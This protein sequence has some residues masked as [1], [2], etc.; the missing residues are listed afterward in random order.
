MLYLDS[1]IGPIH[2]LMIYKDH[3]DPNTFYYIP[4][5][6]R[7][8]RNE[9][10][11]EFIFLKY[12]R[13]ITDN[14]Q[15]SQQQLGGAFLAFTTD[16][17]IDDD[18][19]QAVK[20]QIG[21]TA[22]GTIN[23]TPA[24]FRKGTVRLSI[25]KDMSTAP[26]APGAPAPPPAGMSFFEQ[27]WGASTPSL[28]GT[29]RATFALALDAE[30]ATLFEAAI[31]SGIC[32]IGV[33]YDCEM[34]GLRPGF[35]VKISADYKRI[36][37][38][39]TLQFGIQ[40]SYASI[41]LKAEI[42]LAWEKL[43]E[44]GAIK[45]E[46]INFTDDE[47]LRKQANAAFEFFKG[48]LLQDFFSPAL[49]PPPFMRSAT[50]L[51]T[52]AASATGA[53]QMN[54]MMPGLAASQ[55]AAAR[56]VAQN[57][58]TLAPTVASPPQSQASNVVATALA[59]AAVTGASALARPPAPPPAAPAPAPANLPVAAR[60]PAAS[61][62]ARPNPAAPAPPR[63]AVAAPP[64]PPAAATGTR[65]PI[66]PGLESAAKPQAVNTGYGLQ[67][68]FT[69][70]KVYMDEEKTR[71]FEYSEQDAVAQEV[72][73]Q[74][75]FSTM[76][77]GV[78]LSRLVKE[79]SL[80]DDFF[81]RIN[82]T[83]SMGSDLAAEGV[84]S[85][86]VN[87]EYPANRE[88]GVGP[89]ASDGVIW[90]PGAVPPHTFAAWLDNAKDLDYQYQMDVQFSAQSEWVGKGNRVTSPWIT[91]RARVLT[92]DPLDV[93][94]LFD[95][96]LS[97]GTIDPT[98]QQVQ[99]EVSYDD[100]TNGFSDHRSFLMKAGD[101]PVHWRLRLS[102]PNL[103]TY[104]YRV[105]YVF[106]GN[107]QHTT[108]WTTTDS[109]TL[110]IGNPFKNQFQV[111]VVPILQVS[112]LQ[113]ADV[114]VVYQETVSGYEHRTPLTFN[115]A[116]MATQVVVIPTMSA[117]PTGY[118]FITTVVHQ[119]GSVVQPTTTQ[120]TVDDQVVLVKEGQGA[121]HKITVSLPDTNLAGAGLL[122]VKVVLWGPGDPPDVAEALFSPSTLAP[123]TVLLVQPD[124][125][126]PWSYHY[127]VIGYTALGVPR[128]G[129]PQLASDTNLLVQ[130]PKP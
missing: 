56:P 91:S 55:P 75:L 117:A 120:A 49:Q 42:D 62:P 68:A 43:R 17:G 121:A 114:E 40:G 87:F 97:L 110:V 22:T 106:T 58:S 7:L 112:N 94:A 65:P 71:E 93:M 57:A 64:R 60:P 72:A 8:A 53:A 16:L 38:S 109:A 30:A 88:P 47:N 96:T 124:T 25:A 83:V 52:G 3:A 107:Y 34:L 9:E 44:D 2:G 48:Q 108:D 46:V 90:H 50:G 92:L 70:T 103:R 101:P 12:R 95:L 19:A 119:D 130:L 11:P 13:D 86:A 28:Y 59:N 77:R 79:I 115:P 105:T 125:T 85:V 36:S 10:G 78:D 5:R 82:A 76:V 6:P 100:T 84:D 122:A 118:S 41:G 126:K 35:D 4:E 15:L 21:A 99:V 24:Q 32:P 1:P 111:R 33:I 129:G 128:G 116:A 23:L 31:K 66:P 14:P 123:Q 113:E 18:T 69:L 39:L 29:N 80:D 45:V 127:Q 102:D 74:G 104:Q 51:G 37:E 26:A 20:A 89:M 54:G 63:P 73:P 67:L 61:P 98:V 27:I 81:K